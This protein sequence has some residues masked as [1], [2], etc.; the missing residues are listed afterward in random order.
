MG[1]SQEW[2]T[3]ESIGTLFDH[4]ASMYNE[5]SH[6]YYLHD[7]LEYWSSVSIWSAVCCCKTRQCRCLETILQAF[8]R[9]EILEHG[10]QKS[11]VK[12]RAYCETFKRVQRQRICVKLDAKKCRSLQ[13][14][15]GACLTM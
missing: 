6:S 11:P 15:G 5:D 13:Q 8:R 12:V 4:T 7:L 3:T 14:K 9:L 2:W 10:L 1:M